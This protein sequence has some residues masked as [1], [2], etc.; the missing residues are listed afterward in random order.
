[1]VASYVVVVLAV[2]RIFHRDIMTAALQAL[3]ITGP[4]APYPGV[5]VLGYL[6]GSTAAAIPIDTCSIP[7]LVFQVPCCL[8]LLEIN[9]ANRSGTAKPRSQTLISKIGKA[10]SA[11]V[12]WAP[13]LAIMLVVAGIHFPKPISSS[14]YLLGQ[15][16]GGVAL[17]ATGIVLYSRRITICLPIGLSVF[18]K[19]VALPAAVWGILVALGLP[20]ETI[21]EA[22]VTLALPAATITVILSVQYQAADQEMASTLF[23]STILSALTDGYIHPAVRLNATNRNQTAVTNVLRC[24]M[25]VTGRCVAMR[26]ISEFGEDAGGLPGIL[27]CKDLANGLDQHGPAIHARMSDSVRPSYTAA[28]CEQ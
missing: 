10:L 6:F 3:A 14:L 26:T 27:R 23:M 22:V 20:R 11:P 17:F 13:I 25:G 4:A 1:M 21:R 9:G 15:A 5:P 16:N 28:R 19:K 18:A 7:E 8:V 24:K 2:R 12:V